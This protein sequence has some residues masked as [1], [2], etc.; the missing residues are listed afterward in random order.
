MIA[1]REFLE[2]VGNA[3]VST[4]VE[5][6]DTGVDVQELEDTLLMLKEIVENR[7]LNLKPY[8][9]DFD[10]RNRQEVTQNQFSAVMSTLTIPISQ[11]ELQVLFRAFMV[12][13]GRKE[14][15]RVN[16][17]AFIRRVDVDI[18]C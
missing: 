14:T 12:T 6:E 5:P 17:K 9:Q 15:E 13:E 10:R 2:A 11:R 7:R 1:W 16:Y 4:K 8:F 18:K 3:R